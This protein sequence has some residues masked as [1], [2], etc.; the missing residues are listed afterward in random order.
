MFDP[1]VPAGLQD[2]AETDQIGIDVGMGVFERIAHT[3]LGGEIDD[4]LRP[5]GAERPVNGFPIFQRNAD[6]GEAG[7]IIEPRQAGFFQG[8]IVIVVDVVD[9]DDFVPARQQR[10]RQS[11]AD[12]S[13][14]TRD[15][16]FHGMFS[17]ELRGIRRWHPWEACSSRRI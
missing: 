1:V 11:R 3:G 2:I 10:V 8:D 5:V 13:R 14:G 12:E 9:A 7:V 6:F 17:Q 15:Q 16:H 4:P